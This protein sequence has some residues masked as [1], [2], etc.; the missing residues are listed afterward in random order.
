VSLK[1]LTLSLIVVAPVPPEVSRMLAEYCTT[2][3]MPAVYN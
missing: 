3:V 1:G 2:V